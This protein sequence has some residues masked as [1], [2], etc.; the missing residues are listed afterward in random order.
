M[1]RY[2]RYRLPWW[3]R[4]CICAIEMATLPILIFQLLRTIFFPTTFD[5]LLLGFFIGL[6]VAF[7]L[8]WI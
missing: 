6:Y 1:G 3:M 4:R 8:R 2:Y 5:I 7:Q